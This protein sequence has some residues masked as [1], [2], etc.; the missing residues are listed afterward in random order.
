M[1]VLSRSPLQ[2]NS[3]KQGP[4]SFVNKNGNKD[5]GPLQMKLVNKDHLTKQ[6]RSRETPQI[7]AR[8]GKKGQQSYALLL[9]G[10]DPHKYF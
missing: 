6:E 10:S 3:R 9:R 5:G 2:M 8:H 1:T 7:Q 4:Q